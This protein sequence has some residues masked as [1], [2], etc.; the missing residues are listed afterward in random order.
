MDAIFDEEMPRVR[1]AVLLKHFSQIDDNR[2]P[3]RVVYPLAEVVLLLTC[4]TS[5]RR[6]VS[7]RRGRVNKRTPAIKVRARLSERVRELGIVQ[8][9][10]RVL[11]RVFNCEFSLLV[12]R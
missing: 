12:K 3:W 2:E 1:L 11:A 9:R 7:R 6:S 8:D 5:L 10:A 4:A